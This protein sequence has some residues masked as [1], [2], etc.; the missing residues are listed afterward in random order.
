MGAIVSTAPTGFEFGRG[1]GQGFLEAQLA[2][3]QEPELV[4]GL[5]GKQLQPR[6]HRLIGVGSTGQ[7]CGPGIVDGV[8]QN[9]G[10]FGPDTGPLLC[11][12]GRNGAGQQ[13]DIAERGV[14]RLRGDVDPEGDSQ[15]TQRRGPGWHTGQHRDFPNRQTRQRD[16][17]G[18]RGGAVADDDRLGNVLQTTIP[19]SLDFPD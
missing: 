9:L 1:G 19:P 4:H 15:L 10:P 5:P 3:R 8:E 13:I 2:S 16:Q 18:T 17:Q 11:R 14:H 6:D 7:G 12:G